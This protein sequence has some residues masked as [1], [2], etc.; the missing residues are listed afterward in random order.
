MSFF[1]GFLYVVEVLVCFLLAGVIMLQKPKDGGLNTAIAGGMGEAFFGAQVGNVLVK[2]T[3]TLGTIF[4][5][6]TLLLSCLTSHGR[7][8]SVMDGVRT[9]P[10]P[11][12]QSQPAL[13]FTQGMP[14]N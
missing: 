7:S 3:I 11:A 8:G 4:L 12:E 10:P 1:I 5:V 13:P 9:P 14:S 2:T 6:N